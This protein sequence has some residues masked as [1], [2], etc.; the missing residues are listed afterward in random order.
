[1]NAVY[2]QF[3]VE[4]EDDNGK[5]I[6]YLNNADRK[7]IALFLNND[8]FKARMMAYEEPIARI[9]SKVA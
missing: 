2:H 8:L 7:R 3:I 9:Y 1:M 5:D 6:D 4:I